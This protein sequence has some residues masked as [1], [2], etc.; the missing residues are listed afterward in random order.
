MYSLFLFKFVAELQS[1][2]WNVAWKT[3]ECPRFIH[4]FS[5]LYVSSFDLIF[6]SFLKQFYLILFISFVFQ[7]ESN[8]IINCSPWT[9][10]YTSIQKSKYICCELNHREMHSNSKANC[11]NG[12]ACAIRE[13]H[14]IV[15]ISELC[16]FECIFG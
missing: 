12:D 5:I 4:H 10:C 3:I 15:S 1:L 14:K 16:K 11:T 6:N 13:S 2:L 7:R 9:W 8:M